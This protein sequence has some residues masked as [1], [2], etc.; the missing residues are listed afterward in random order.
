MSQTS[1][2]R[3]PVSVISYTGNPGFKYRPRLAILNY[4]FC[5]FPQ[6]IQHIP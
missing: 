2:G 1:E 5:G 4:D 3:S 6:F